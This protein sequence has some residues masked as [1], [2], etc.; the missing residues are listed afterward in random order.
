[1]QVPIVSPANND[2]SCR[3]MTSVLVVGEIPAW[4]GKR[5]RIYL[6]C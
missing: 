2:Y 3:E 4:S 6:E 1:M 5:G